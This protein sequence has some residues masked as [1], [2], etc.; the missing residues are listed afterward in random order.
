MRQMKFRNDYLANNFQKVMQDTESILKKNLIFQVAQQQL[1]DEVRYVHHDFNDSLEEQQNRNHLKQDNDLLK[2]IREDIGRSN[3][4]GADIIASPKKEYG[5]GIRYDLSPSRNIDYDEV[6]NVYISR[7]RM[8][9]SPNRSPLP[10]VMVNR[11]ELLDENLLQD[12]QIGQI[13]Y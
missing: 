2:R 13:K 12:Y 8:E 4:P 1:E 9:R 10:V 6:P 5:G 11:Q 7:P 3:R